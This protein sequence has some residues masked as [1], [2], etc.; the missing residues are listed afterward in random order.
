VNYHDGGLALME[1]DGVVLHVDTSQVE[2]V[3]LDTVEP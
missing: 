1:A 2:Q 3:D